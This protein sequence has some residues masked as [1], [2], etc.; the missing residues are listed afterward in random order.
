MNKPPNYD[1][2]TLDYLRFFYFGAAGD[3]EL[4]KGYL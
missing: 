4:H 3:F 2:D 1:Q